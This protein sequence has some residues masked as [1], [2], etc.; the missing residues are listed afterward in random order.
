[1]ARQKESV[2]FVAADKVT[3]NRY[4]AAVRR[5]DNTEPQV[6]RG[7]A[8]LGGKPAYL[9]TAGSL[10]MEV[11]CAIVKLLDK[12][13]RVNSINEEDIARQLRRMRR[14]AA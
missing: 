5:F 11:C 10:S 8:V 13:C 2:N 12:G 3:A 1:M 14:S 6:T 9:V 7:T 4:V